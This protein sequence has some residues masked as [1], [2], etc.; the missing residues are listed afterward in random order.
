MKKQIIFIIVALFIVAAAVSL[1][2]PA[3]S[4]NVN[5]TVYQV[6]LFAPTICF[7]IG[8]TVL[9]LFFYI[10]F[11]FG[12]AAIAGTLLIIMPGSIERSAA[13]FSDRDGWC[14][15]LGTLAVT[16]YLWK[17]DI[18]SK[19]LRYLCTVLSGFFVFL[20]GLSWEGFGGLSSQL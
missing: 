7:L 11:G 10:R 3:T 2:L 4:V 16:T 20:G 14:W 1:Y 8:M 9:C 5:V 17:E 12:V 19:R 6:Q 15:M 18:T 13:G